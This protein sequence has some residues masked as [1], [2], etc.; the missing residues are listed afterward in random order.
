MSWEYE[1]VE[2]RRR[3]FTPL[4]GRECRHC[5]AWHCHGCV[6]QHEAA[7]DGAGG[8]FSFF[9]SRSRRLWGRSD[10]ERCDKRYTLRA[11]RRT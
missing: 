8:G 4:D 9:S 1:C 10:A 5:E 6:L 11:S 2:C 3:D 7:P